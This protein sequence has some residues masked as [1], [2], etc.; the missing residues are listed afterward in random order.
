MF[1]KISFKLGV[2]NSTIGFG[3]NPKN[4]KKP[5]ITINVIASLIVTSVKFLVLVSPNI[6]V[7]S[8]KYELIS[9]R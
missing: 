2:T 8:G 4:N 6:D 9:E 1:D 3:Y 7:D 5:M